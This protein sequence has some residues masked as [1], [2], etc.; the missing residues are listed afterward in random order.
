MIEVIGLPA[1]VWGHHTGDLV[2]GELGLGGDIELYKDR[3][4][5]IEHYD[6]DDEGPDIEGEDWAE[7]G[8]G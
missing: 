5:I 1:Y 4:A 2:R 3:E 8:S 7:E 6:F